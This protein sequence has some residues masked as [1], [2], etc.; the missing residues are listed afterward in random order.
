M[1]LFGARDDIVVA[2][3]PSTIPPPPLCQCT[4]V[5]WM[6]YREAIGH[7]WTGLI[8]TYTNPPTVAAWGLG[9]VAKPQPV[10]QKVGAQVCPETQTQFDYARR[11]QITAAQYAQIT[12]SINAKI[13]NPGT[14]QVHDYNCTTWVVELLKGVVNITVNTDSR[15]AGSAVI[16]NYTDTP[17]YTPQSMHETLVPLPTNQTC[18]SFGK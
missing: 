16:A 10:S 13:K 15:A 4:I 3:W 9:P 1:L 5:Y 17:F 6:A 8:N 12:A 7:T 2:L 14:Y 11:F 18:P